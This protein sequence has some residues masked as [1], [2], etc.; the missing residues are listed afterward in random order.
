MK[1]GIGYDIHRLVENRKLFLGGVEIPFEKG[2]LGHSDGDAL[3]HTIAD[4]ILGALAL[5]DIGKHFPPGD[6][7]WKDIDSKFILKEVNEIVKSSNYKVANIDSNII[8]EKPK[9][10]P[11]VEK[12]RETISKILE[13]DI[14]GVSVKARTN[15]GLDSIGNGEAIA[16]QAIVLLEK[17]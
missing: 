15:E 13:I 7:T 8:A 1:I 17:K 16:T 5:G 6:P 14:K 12:M 3:L 11:F 4:A 10:L 2:L 9:M